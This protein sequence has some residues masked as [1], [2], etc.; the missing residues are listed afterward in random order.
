MRP[1]AGPT[2][3]APSVL[4]RARRIYG[5]DPPRPGP[6]AMLVEGERV[7]WVGGEPAPNAGATVDLGDA[8]VI[9]G[10]VDSHF[11]MLCLLPTAGWADLRT[12]RSL[13]DARRSFA[14]HAGEV[15]EG[16]WVVGWGFD[17][18]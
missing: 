6:T 7:A 11:H 13:H 8:V 4:L 10:F 1:L 15:P 3:S 16:R 12:A 17:A 14:A 18:A 2:T 9:P 5:G